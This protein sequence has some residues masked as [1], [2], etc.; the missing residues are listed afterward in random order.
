MS[1]EVFKCPGCQAPILFRAE[2]GLWKCDYCGS[3]YPAETIA[4]PH[5]Q[6][7]TP[8]EESS[9][10]ATLEEC[11]CSECGAA[12]L[13]EANESA[14][15]CVYC[16]SPTLIR[17]RFSGRFEPKWVIPFTVSSAKA[18]EIY[19]QYIRKHFLAPASMKTAQEVQNI[20][21]LYAPFWLFDCHIE[22]SVTGE[23][24]KISHYSTSTHNVTQTSYYRVAR[25]GSANYDRIPADGSQH[26][27]NSSIQAIEPYDYAKL[28]PFHPAYMSGAYAERFDVDAEQSRDIMRARAE[29][30]LSSRL[31]GTIDG[32][33]S[34]SAETS[35][36]ATTQQQCEYALLPLYL[37]T[38]LHQGSKYLFLVNGQTGKIYGEPPID[39]KYALKIFLGLFLACWL[40]A[41][42]VGA[43]LYAD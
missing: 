25:M 5:R 7:P 17:S 8:N 39:K 36:F 26:L 28:V 1:V 30:F 3:E 19:F 10:E 9:T 35:N 31:T 22:G 13:C 2:L 33:D 14:T 16:K 21:A 29:S 41:L 40:I 12:I 4:V 18:Q 24:K 34:F 15:F 38:T 11:H 6:S 27:D 20:R 23:G 43:F 32:Y 42:L 37:L